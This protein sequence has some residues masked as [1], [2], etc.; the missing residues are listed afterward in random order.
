MTNHS[1][2]AMLA[3]T[4]S[5]IV[6]E[7]HALAPNK[8]GS[9][10]SLSLE[11]L[12]ALCERRLVRIGLSAT[13][14]PIDEVARFLGGRAPV[15]IVQPP[16]QKTFELRVSVPIEDMTEPRLLVTGTLPPL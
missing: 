3:S 11:R 16:A 2:F 13:Q 1:W 14:R 9:H 7:I 6:D 5:V 15:S 4:R 12:E 10:L 8:R